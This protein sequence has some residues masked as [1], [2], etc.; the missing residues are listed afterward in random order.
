[1]PAF[2]QS[3]SDLNPIQI[4]ITHVF[5]RL[6]PQPSVSFV[7]RPLDSDDLTKEASRLPS[8]KYFSLF[9][10]THLLGGV[11][12]Q[13]IILVAKFRTPVF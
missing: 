12:D 7:P 8:I 10:L 2:N 11:E 13:S 1:M 5:P 6:R 9:K 4:F 3:D